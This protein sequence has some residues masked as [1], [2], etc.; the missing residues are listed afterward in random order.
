MRPKSASDSLASSFP[1]RFTSNATKTSHRTKTSQ[2]NTHAPST[3]PKGWARGSPATRVQVAT[4]VEAPCEAPPAPPAADEADEEDD[5]E[6]LVE[7]GAAAEDDALE[8]AAALLV[9]WPT[10]A[11]AR[12]ASE[13]GARATENFIS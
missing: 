3:Q 11:C 7:E 5:D 2:V 12:R 8:G 4:G 6:A 13:R 9:D 1:L 10:T